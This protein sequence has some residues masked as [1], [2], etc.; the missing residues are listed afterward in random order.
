MSDGTYDRHLKI[1]WRLSDRE[2]QT[3]SNRLAET[4]EYLSILTRLWE[5]PIRRNC[6]STGL[7]Y[8]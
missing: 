1:V 4:M 2:H 3:N 7:D 6:V 5:S 8:C